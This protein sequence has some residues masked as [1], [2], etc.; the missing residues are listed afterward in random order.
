MW[1]GWIRYSGEPGSGQAVSSRTGRVGDVV[2]G[3]VE[4]DRVRFS[5]V[6]WVRSGELAVWSGCVYTV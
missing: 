6:L 5:M 2:P 3:W 1:R 4:S